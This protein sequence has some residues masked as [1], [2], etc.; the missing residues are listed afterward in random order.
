MHL[1]DLAQILLLLNFITWIDESHAQIR[2]DTL[3]VVRSAIADKRIDQASSLLKYY[4]ESHPKDFNGFW[5]YAQTEYWLKNFQHSEQLYEQAIGIQ[6]ANAYLQLDY[7]RML[8]N[9]GRY[10]KA[11][12]YLLALKAFD[13]T[14]EPALYEMAKSF[15]WQRN[16]IRAKKEIEELLKIDPKNEWAQ[17]LLRDILITSSAWLKVSTGFTSDTQPL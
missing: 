9:I 6:P 1:K 17:N 10:H 13:V 4:C 14:R 2:Q 3:S 7:A 11:Q 12:K 8:T 16:N 5:L 15:Y